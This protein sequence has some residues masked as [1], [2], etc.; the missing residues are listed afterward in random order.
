[1][2]KRSFLVLFLIFPILA[3]GQI[4]PIAKKFDHQ[5]H[6]ANVF[7]KNNFQCSECHNIDLSKGKEFK[8][9]ESLNLNTFKLKPREM[10]HQCHQGTAY[11]NAPKECFTCHNTTDKLEVIKPL[12]H[13]NANWKNGAHAGMARTD[14]ATCLNC[15]NNNQCIKCH[16]GR[17]EVMNQ[18]HSKN[19]RYF[20]SIEARMNPN[21]CESCHTETYC[22]RCHVGGVK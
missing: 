6:M 3:L 14:S 20:H 1:M 10:C 2:I 13:Q 9:N 8:I 16:V 18:N 19:F 7:V 11:P 17:N 15:H 5:F 12:S 22:I 4:N 21:K